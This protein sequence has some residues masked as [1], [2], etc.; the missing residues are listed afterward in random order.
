MERTAVRWLTAEESVAWRGFLG[1]MRALERGADRQLAECSGLSL[2][3]YQLLVPLSECDERAM[4]ARD[5]GR[6]VNWER[7]RIS[8]QLRRMEERG[9]IERRDCP[10]DGRGTVVVLTR[11]GMRAIEQ[12]APSHVEW[13]RQNFVDLLS[14]EE[15]EL[16]GEICERV[17][18]TVAGS[19]GATE[20]AS[21]GGS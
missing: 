1:A 4:R 15:I 14:R 21:D 9:L 3:D 8:H 10:S 16:L 18:R 12:A 17:V 2:A 11:L 7:S 19:C 6:H 5:L 20:A 13:V